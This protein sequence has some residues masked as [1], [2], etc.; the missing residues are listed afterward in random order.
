MVKWEY[1]FQLLEDGKICPSVF[2]KMGQEGWG[3]VCITQVVD[4]HVAIFKRSIEEELDKMKVLYVTGDS[5]YSALMFDQAGYNNNEKL[6]ELW[7]KANN[8]E[9]KEYEL[10]FKLPFPGDEEEIVYCT[11][12]EFGESDPEFIEFLM[13]KFADYDDLKCH[14]WYEV[15]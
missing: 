2:D 11:A 6:Q 4:G 3:L 12:Y 10:K 14:N 15:Y 5:D 9:D 1:G 13:D 8:N 7:D